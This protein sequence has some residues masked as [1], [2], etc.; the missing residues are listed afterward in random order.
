MNWGWPQRLRKMV[1][2]RRSSSLFAGKADRAQVGVRIRMVAHLVPLGKN[3][4]YYVGV[5]LGLI[6][7]QKEIGRYAV[8]FKH[9]EQVRRVY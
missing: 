6:A 5:A 9:V 7:Q 3:A 2:V 1:S 8:F 4:L